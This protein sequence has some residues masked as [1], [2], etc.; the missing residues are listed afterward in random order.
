M[1]NSLSLIQ[2]NKE[3]NDKEKQDLFELTITQ[4]AEIQRL[5]M[6]NANIEKDNH[7]I[8]NKLKTLEEKVELFNIGNKSFNEAQNLL[9]KMSIENIELKSDI[10]E[11]KLE[12]ENLINELKF[13]KETFSDQ[14]NNYKNKLE[15][16]EEKLKELSVLKVQN[17]KLNNKLKE[18]SVAQV[19]TQ[20]N[21]NEYD[22]HLNEKVMTLISEKEQL[23]ENLNKVKAELLKER[24]KVREFEYEKKKTDIENKLTFTMS[25]N[26]FFDS[27]RKN[28]TNLFNNQSEVKPF[29]I[30]KNEDVDDS[31]I[32]E[33]DKMNN[34]YN[35]LKFD[36]QQYDDK[37]EYLK[38]NK[39]QIEEIHGLTEEN[40][41]LI[42]EKD[43]IES[44]LSK[45][46]QLKEKYLLDKE[47]LELDLSKLELQNQKLEMMLQKNQFIE[48]SL[49]SKD[50]S[51]KV[52]IENMIKKIDKL[53][54]ENK[55][56][57]QE[58]EKLIKEIKDS[59]K[60]KSFKLQKDNNKAFES[61]VITELSCLKKENDRLKE[62]NNKIS[63][64][65]NNYIEKNKEY[66]EEILKLSMQIND[67]ISKEQYDK[68]KSLY[69]KLKLN[70]LSEHELISSNLYEFTTL[71][72][73]LKNQ[74]IKRDNGNEQ[75]SNENNN[76]D[77]DEYN[78]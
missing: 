7:T 34:N 62:E 75:G 54:R 60:K 23:T 56:L 48:E 78:Y 57:T 46:T 39:Q 19:K 5:K 38:I 45:E 25:Q 52:E 70:V 65:V 29:A 42:K 21:F 74:F 10:D 11:Y 28:S 6:L 51:H 77:D 50:L 26:N 17:T 63:I 40:N 49:E 73:D 4:E 14:L 76:E 67:M 20:N 66:S 59:T 53:D 18:Y 61:N 37:L 22:N 68:L 69:D 3:E 43:I 8:R 30:N 2:D 27:N 35:L 31:F 71:V 58:K 33:I 1:M 41:K 13:L 32:I 15:L 16:N 36:T 55:S 64:D 12:K 44:F 72:Y 9:S 47:K 24:E